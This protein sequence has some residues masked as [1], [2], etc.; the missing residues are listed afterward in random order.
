MSEDNK[1]SGTQ[2]PQSSQVRSAFFH[3]YTY[4][5]PYPLSLP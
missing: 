5:Y 1:D 3:I 4:T 2:T